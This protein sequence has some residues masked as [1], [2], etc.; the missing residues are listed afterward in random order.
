M[1]KPTITVYAAGSL[2]V[3][4]PQLLK[5]FAG[6]TSIAVEVRHGP[7]G[8]LRERIEAGERPDLYASAD[9]GHPMRLAEQ[10]IVEAPQIFA[11]NRIVA[12]ARKELGL[13]RGNFIEKLLGDARIATSTPKKDP[14]GDYAF[15]IFRRID[16]LH[17]GAFAS[18][19]ARAQMLVGGSETQNVPG[20]YGPI[21]E[22]LAAGTAD[23][24]LGYATGMAS[25]A[26]EVPGTE[27][28]ELPDACRVVPDYTMAIVKGGK[29]EARELALFMLS[30]DG[31]RLLA[32]AGF[33]PVALPS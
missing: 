11:R 28:V 15:E 25:L 22:A 7:A 20:T 6:L 19:E 2:R 23:L 24:S 10:G 21:G 31:Q 14:S 3:A 5:A 17:P 18:L 29:P 9:F 16:A 26:R 1:N 32:A 4:M 12:V 13:T 33:V 8:I 27:L 30:V